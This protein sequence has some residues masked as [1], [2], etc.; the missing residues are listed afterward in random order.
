MLPVSAVVLY[1]NFVNGV[2]WVFTIQNG[3]ASLGGGSMSTPT[4]LPGAKGDLVVPSKLRNT[5]TLTEYT[6]TNISSYA[7]ANHPDITS[8]SVPKS[9]VTIQSAAFYGCS[10]LTNMVLPF[11]GKKRTPVDKMKP[12]VN[13]G[14]NDEL[15]GYVFGGEADGMVAVQQ[16]SRYF[17]GLAGNSGRDYTTFYVP[18]SLESVTITDETS[19][20]YGSFDNL[21]MLK[22]IGIPE[23]LK[24]ICGSSFEGCTSLRDIYIDDLTAW[25][26]VSFESSP[27]SYARNLYLNGQLVQDLI[28]PQGV[29]DVR[30]G[31]FSAYIP[32]IGNANAETTYNGNTGITSV[33]IP[34]SVTNV[35]S[36]AFAGCSSITNMVLSLTRGLGTFFSPG[37]EFGP[38]SYNGCRRVLQRSSNGYSHV[39]YIPEALK[40]VVVTGVSS[41]EPYMFENCD[42]LESVVLPNSVTNIGDYAFSRCIGLTKMDIGRNVK[43]IGSGAFS[44][45]GNMKKINISDMEAWCDIEF[46]SAGANPLY[47]AHDLFLN[48]EKVVE[49]V[50]PE[51]KKSIG[52]YIFY[53]CTNLTSIVV[54]SSVT[55]IAFEAFAGCSSLTNMVLPFVGLSRNSVGSNAHFGSIFGGKVYDGSNWVVQDGTRVSQKYLSNGRAYYSEYYIPAFLKSVSITDTAQIGYCAFYGCNMIERITLPPA[56][57]TIDTDAFYGCSALSEVHISDLS[58]WAETEFGNIYANPLYYAPNNLYLNGERVCGAISIDEGTIRIGNYSFYGYDDITSVAFPRSLTEVGT[59]AFYGCT[60]VAYV[61]VSDASLWAGVK[62]ANATANPVGY[63]GLLTCNGVPVTDIVVP[64]GTET[65]TYAFNGCTNMTSISIPTSVTNINSAAFAGCGALTNMVLPSKAFANYGFGSLFGTASYPGGSIV[66]QRY[67]STSSSTRTYYVPASLKSITIIGNA[68]ISYAAFQNCSMIEDVTFLG[69][70]PSVA[71]IAFS[72]CSALDAVNITNLQSWCSIMFADSTSNPLY[73]AKR[74]FL[75]G[76][77]VDDVDISEGV[78]NVGSYVFIG[79]TNLTS[80]VLADSVNTIS[81]SAFSGCSGLTNVV[82]GAG[83]QSVGSSAFANCSRLSSV[84]IPD[85]ETWS[86]TSFNDWSANPLY[87]GGS[88]YENGEL[89]KE[90]D[91]AMASDRIGSYA[92]A[93]Y[94]GLERVAFGDSVVQI[95]SS[96]FSGCPNI[97]NVVIGGSVLELGASSFAGCTKLKSVSIGES[98]TNIGA[99]AFNSCK[100]LNSVSLPDSVKAIGGSAFSYCSALREL[101]IGNGVESIDYDA[102]RDCRN[103]EAVYI[104]DL[105]AWCNITY[106]NAYAPP[107]YNSRGCMLYLYGEPVGDVVLS[108][109]TTNITSFAFSY[110]TNLT[111]LTIPASVTQIG[112]YALCNCSNL[113]NLLFQGNAPTGQSYALSNPAKNCRA[114]VSQLSWGWNVAIP[115]TRNGVPIEYFDYTPIPEVPLSATPDTVAAALRDMADANLRVNIT[116]V[117][118]YIAWRN[119][120]IAIT[121]SASAGIDAEYVR[122]ASHSWFSFAIGSPTLISKEIAKDDVLIEDFALSATGGAFD[123]TVGIDGVEIG[124]AAD[125]ERLKTVFSIEGATELSESAFTLDN[126]TVEAVVPQGGK[127]KLTAKPKGT[128]STFFMRVKVK[129]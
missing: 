36:M 47:Y 52:Q 88:L 26:Q 3:Y 93:N 106:G 79:Y 4:L 89:V 75:N 96:A 34:D 5:A 6:V 102:F 122:D 101:V 57:E 7:F 104:S 129:Q 125:M 118:E 35:A 111:S 8:I 22:K 29:G 33:T 94:V 60:N 10:S 128:A 97:T 67:S 53:G 82:W 119:W 114:Q 99:S 38:A 91:E 87:Y 11:V 65:I 71:G 110:V 80:V 24:R 15:F 107:T 45:C 98:V 124:E 77:L 48:G 1:T 55:N 56:L 103:L 25:C 50:M 66:R 49:C 13:V 90:L 116:N 23:T 20:F 30:Q 51:G 121:N 70:I 117:A 113:T 126:M 46:P 44:G 58:A 62:F 68:N 21:A 59:D 61:D 78:E 72:G 31:V 115:G 39:Y 76:R 64:D 74:L 123:F 84:H 27:M 16:Y 14:W 85:L 32:H 40:S 127:V 43:R 108:A 83:V 69:D 100:A 28:I 42:M 9:I 37:S 41:I 92:F 120:T 12:G 73:Y 81:T 18:S 54:P 105:D 112:S 109:E 95:G 86:R 17:Y 2:N 63:A 19:F